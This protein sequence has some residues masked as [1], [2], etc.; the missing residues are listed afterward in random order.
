MQRFPRGIR[1]HRIKVGKQN[2]HRDSSDELTF[3]KSCHK[4]VQIQACEQRTADNFLDEVNVL[5]V[6]IHLTIYN[7]S[8]SLFKQPRHHLLAFFLCIKHTLRDNILVRKLIHRI[9]V[10]VGHD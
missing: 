6:Y 3:G 5:K 4:Y 10:A 9:L 2:E 1:H 8:N 7:K